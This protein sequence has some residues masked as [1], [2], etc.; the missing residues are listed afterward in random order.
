MKL[1]F[2]SIFGV[3][4]AAILGSLLFSLH[5]QAEELNRDFGIETLY[6]DI[7]ILEELYL[8]AVVREGRNQF[9]SVRLT[10]DGFEM[11]PTVFD[12]HNNV[13]ENVLNNR[14]LYR[15]NPWIDPNMKIE[16][17]DFAILLVFNQNFM[18]ERQVE[19]SVTVSVQ[20][21]ASGNTRRET[22]T[23][24]E[25]SRDMQ[26]SQSFMIEHNGTIYYVVGIEGVRENYTSHGG[27]FGGGGSS[28]SMEN[29]SGG[30]IVYSFDPVS[31]TMELEFEGAIFHDEAW[32]QWFATDHGVYV[33]FT[34]WGDN[35]EDPEIIVYKIDLDSQTAALIEDVELQEF[36]EFRGHG[37]NLIYIH[38][39]WDQEMNSG[40]NTIHIV[41][42]Q[43][44]ESQQFPF[45]EHED[46]SS[47]SRE[48]TVS[49]DHLFVNMHLSTP[50]SRHDIRAAQH[51]HIMIYDLQ[52]ME[53]VYE[54][55]IRLRH[56]QGLL[57]NV[58]W[59]QGFTLQNRD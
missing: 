20:D 28:W 46:S 22:I 52:T 37:D 1:K 33:F 50:P 54:G 10:P 30:F 21:R 34:V 57:G 48:M 3:L 42:M 8:G 16:T 6:G 29:S 7:S 14:E 41:N 4:G 11:R 24:D 9:T 5:G 26:I 59:F 49:G 25:I 35:N 56:D 17:D 2:L 13:G 32:P 18:W 27:F 23:L 44:G 39:E 19:P 45:G 53:L 47:W 58:H 36:W 43:T 12:L 40:K 31:M 15:G 55:R 51:Q 38:E